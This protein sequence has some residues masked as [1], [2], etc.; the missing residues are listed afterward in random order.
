MKLETPEHD[1]RLVMD[2]F[3]LYT[4]DGSEL[5]THLTLDDALAELDRLKAA[6]TSGAWTIQVI[7]SDGGS[8]TIVTART[9]TI[10]AP[11]PAPRR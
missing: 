5:S 6:T 9:G 7:D 11:A 10:T 2:R 1:G 4:D 3:T 8:E